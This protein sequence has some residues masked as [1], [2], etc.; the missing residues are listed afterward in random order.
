MSL[1]CCV[2]LLEASGEVLSHTQPLCL[3]RC[4]GAL[5][6]LKTAVRNIGSTIDAENSFAIDNLW[7]EIHPLQGA[8]CGFVATVHR[9]E[10][11][12]PRA[13]QRLTA[14]QLEVASHAADGATCSEIAKSLR[15]SVYTVRQHLKDAYR[16]L[17]VSNRVQ[18][19][20]ALKPFVSLE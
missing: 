11:L 19:R 18:L 2:V 10:L 7:V 12:H 6:R 1:C 14:R 5:D 16:R 13:A 15:I 8:V 3:N 4:P 9:V 17:E 20:R